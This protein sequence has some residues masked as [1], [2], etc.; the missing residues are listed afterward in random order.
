M[1]QVSEFCIIFAVPKQHNTVMNNMYSP[2]V[3]VIKNIKV[4]EV[5]TDTEPK[6]LSPYINIVKNDLFALC[7]TCSLPYSTTEL[8][9]IGNSRL[10]IICADQEFIYEGKGKSRHAAVSPKT[11]AVTI[12]ENQFGSADTTH[13]KKYP[14]IYLS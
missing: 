8:K 14:I 11:K 3:K 7:G 10:D 2:A 5:F 9:L 12:I 13:V 1:I 4:K 6:S